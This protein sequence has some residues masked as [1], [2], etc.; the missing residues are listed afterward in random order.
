MSIAELVAFTGIAAIV[1]SCEWV[2]RVNPDVEPQ[3]PMEQTLMTISSENAFT[4]WSVTRPFIRVK[5]T[6]KHECGR[7]MEQTK[8]HRFRWDEAERVADEW[9]ET[10]THCFDECG[11]AA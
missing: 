3:H 2:Q 4:S 10:W 7:H 6:A 1:I 9:A 11:V 8:F 5:V